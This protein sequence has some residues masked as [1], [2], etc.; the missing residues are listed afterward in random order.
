MQKFKS[1]KILFIFLAF[2]V[3]LAKYPLWNSLGALITI[4]LLNFEGIND[5]LKNFKISNYKYFFVSIPLILINYGLLFLISKV[6]PLPENEVLLRSLVRV[7]PLYYFL[8]FGVLSPICEELTFRYGFNGI[9]NKY[10]YMIFT[11]ILYAVMHLSSFS[12]ILYAIP[13]FI[14]G[15]TFSTIYTKTN[16]IYCSTISHILN[17]TITV[18][19]ILLF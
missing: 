16:N 5:D 11:S 3:F 15:L 18:L 8:I 17:N 10:I 4:Y 12:E 19:I 14:L 1:I 13:Y 6:S 9:K 2:N 7:S